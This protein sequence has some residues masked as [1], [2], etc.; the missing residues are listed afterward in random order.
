M[1]EEMEIL[2][3]KVTVLCENG[4]LDLLKELVQVDERFENDQ[5]GWEFGDVKSWTGGHIPKLINE[6]II[7]YGYKSSNYTHFRLAIDRAVLKT[8]LEAYEE[9]IKPKPESEEGAQGKPILDTVLAKEFEELVTRENDLLSFWGQKL[10]PR[11]IGMDMER[12]ACLVCLASPGDKS[13][14][15]RRS[16]TLI[17]GPPGTAKTILID[18]IKHHLGAVG[19]GPTSSEAGLKFD[20][21]ASGTE[22][23][24]IM[25]H[26]GTL[27]IEEIDKLD[28]R[29]LEALYE[30][31][32]NGE[33]E[34]HKGDIR[35]TFRAEI[36]VIA[37]GNVIDKLPA[38]LLDRFDMRFY[39]QIPSKGIEK[40]IT[41]DLYQDWLVDKEDYRG[42]KLRAYLEYVKDYEP[43]ITPETMDKCMRLK[44]A[45]I[46]LSEKDPNIRE[47]EAFLRV[48]YTIAKIN[49]KPMTVNDFL[50]AIKLVDPQINGPKTMALEMLA[51]ELTK[52]PPEVPYARLA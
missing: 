32:S 33:F 48:A 17:Y 27:V 42:E 29:A 36:R 39:V 14:I 4:Y 13:G 11:I 46:D 30:A 31:M 16:H 1:D 6:G 34:V 2:A 7:R 44:N 20:A 25:A 50:R 26:G 41:D 10:N 40:K 43:A 49:R 15:R 35:K 12:Q 52:P 28:R 21:R 47:K 45:Y 5:F 38:P 9:S 51:K 18:Y 24:L 23:A 37:V 8:I 22:G 19:V 3:Q